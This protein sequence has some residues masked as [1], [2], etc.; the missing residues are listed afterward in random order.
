MGYTKLASLINSKKKKGVLKETFEG[1]LLIIDEAHNIRP[2]DK[3][4][5]KVSSSLNML[6]EEVHNMRIL[7]LSATPMFDNYREI[8]HVIN[9][10]LKNE[11][12]PILIENEIFGKDGP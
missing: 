7:L 10:L 2:S 4:Q 6:V 5:K 9:I 12:K 8:I 11:K 1:R 3:K